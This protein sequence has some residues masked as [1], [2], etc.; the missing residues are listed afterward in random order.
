MSTQIDRAGVFRGTITESTVN[1]TQ[2]GMPQFVF[3]LAATEKYVEDRDEMAAFELAEPAWVDWSAYDQTITGYLQLVYADR[4][5][6][7]I[8]EMGNLTAVQ[9]AIGWDGKSFAEL[10]TTSWAGKTVLVRVEEN[11]YNGKVTYRVQD[12]DETEAPVHRG[13]RALDADGLKAL[14]A[15]FGALLAGGGK[16]AAAA[17]APAKPAA[18]KPAAP[19]KPVAAKPVAAKPAAAA[20]AAPAAAKPKAPPAVKNTPVEVTD[21]SSVPA[22]MTKDEA[23]AMLSEEAAALGDDK[24]AEIW[25]EAGGVIFPD[26][27]ESSATGEQWAAL[28]RHALNLAEIPF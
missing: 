23:W 8:K 17:K 24:L 20:A 3:T 16:P 4:Q 6:G 15:Q 9:R 26:G 27:D 7:T 13:L 10:G 14:D 25:Q 12:I 19:A 11:D 18:A 22:S 2:K 21:T 1:A 5:D 28:T